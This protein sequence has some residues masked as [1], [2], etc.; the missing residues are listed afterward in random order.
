MFQTYIF[1]VPIQKSAIFPKILVPFSVVL[2][3]AVK[4][5]VLGLMP[6]NMF[7]KLLWYGLELLEDF[8]PS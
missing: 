6:T 2:C 5:W 3:L 7:L 8:R 4:I 1:P